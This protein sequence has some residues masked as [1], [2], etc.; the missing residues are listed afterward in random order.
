M[1]LMVDIRSTLSSKAAR[2]STTRST[3]LDFPLNWVRNV[4]KL[5]KSRRF[6]A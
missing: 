1:I 6:D 5:R 3:A 2:D 4:N